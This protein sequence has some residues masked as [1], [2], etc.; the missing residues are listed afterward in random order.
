MSQRV[1]S[2]NDASKDPGFLLDYTGEF[3]SPTTTRSLWIFLKFTGQEGVITFAGTGDCCWSGGWRDYTFKPTQ[4]G[5]DLI[6]GDERNFFHA[7]IGPIDDEHEMCGANDRYL[8]TRRC[9]AWLRAN[10]LKLKYE[11]RL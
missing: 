9:E 2:H 11:L 3:T 7:T 5:F 10:E 8:F 4:T 6:P 1:I